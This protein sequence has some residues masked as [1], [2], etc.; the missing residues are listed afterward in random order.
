[1]SA[2]ADAGHAL[3]EI[4]RLS[5]GSSATVNPATLISGLTTNQGAGGLFGVDAPGRMDSRTLTFSP[6]PDT[7]ISSWTVDVA[8][9]YAY[10]WPTMGTW[11]Q[12]HTSW[13]DFNINGNPGEYAANGTYSGG[14]AGAVYAQVDQSSFG[15]GIEQ[16]GRVHLT[17]MAVQLTDASAPAVADAPPADALFGAPGASGW[18][19]DATVSVTVTASDRGLGVRRL[20]LRDSA[21]RV[22][23][24]PLPGLPASCATKDPSTSL[25]GGD[26]YTA[27]VPCRTAATQYV[28]PVDLTAM[29]DGQYTLELGVMDAS[30]RATY[31]P[32]T[33]RVNV[34]A[35]GLNPPPGGGVGLA[36]PGTPC[37]NGVIDDSGACIT[38]APS[39]T[40]PPVLSGVPTEGATLTTDDGGWDDIDGATYEYGWV[41]CDATGSGCSPIPAQSGPVLTLTAAMVDATV[42]SVVTATT[43]AGSTT[44]RSAPSWPIGRRTGAGGSG[45]GLRDVVAT[46]ATGGGGA[47][48][49]ITIAADDDELPVPSPTSVSGPNG[50]RADGTGRIDASRSSTGVITGRLTTRSGTPI[51]DAQVDVVVHVAVAGASGTIAGAVTTNDAGEFRYVPQTGVSRIFTFGYRASLS[52]TAYTDHVSIAAPTVAAVSLTAN[53]SR[54]RN[55]Q[56]LR[57]RGA[58][59]LAPDDAHQPVAIQKLT[60]HGWRTIASTRLR[61]G[62]FTWSYRFARTT[63]ATTYRFRAVVPSSSD[64]PLQRGRSVPRDVRVFPGRTR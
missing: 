34:N 58:V 50:I 37:A 39:S 23:R 13:G 43:A 19:T 36:D 53:R 35:P 49:R 56:I 14:P 17:R 1:M 63:V 54:L 32:T 15:S 28:V 11:T 4:G 38:R 61:H 64:W 6:P 12:L 21:G 44:A 10:G 59:A 26:T 48:G 27:S 42:R 29:G 8:S 55:G 24:I 9:M 20:L 22:Q 3:L 62:A 30:G 51:A 16:A 41:I 47:G 45:A 7:S 31:A 25:Y 57:L 5:D 18:Y 40:T 60:E 52:D 2:S 33:Y 46:A